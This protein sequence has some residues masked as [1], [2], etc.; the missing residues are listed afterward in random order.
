MV[1][2]IKRMPL[3]ESHIQCLWGKQ[4]K[5]FLLTDSDPVISCLNMKWIKSDP[6]LQG[7]LNFVLDRL[8]ES[9]RVRVLYVSTKINRADKHTK[10][11]HA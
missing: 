11:I 9:D 4:P 3:Y 8:N 7:L 2:V 10:F 5:V 6:Q 1:D